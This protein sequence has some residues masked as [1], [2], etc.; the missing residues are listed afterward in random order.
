MRTKREHKQDKRNDDSI[1]WDQGLYP[2]GEKRRKKK[3]ETEKEKE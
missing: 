3:R 2:K 1:Q